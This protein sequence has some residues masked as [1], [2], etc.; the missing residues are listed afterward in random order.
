MTRHKLPS[1]GQ[2]KS[3]NIVA[4]MTKALTGRLLVA[5]AVSALAACAAPAPQTDAPA[6]SGVTAV[7]QASKSSADYRRVTRNGQEYY[8]K[9]QKVT[10]SLT[11]VVETCLTAA[12][13]EAQRNDA[14]DYVNKVQGVPGQPAGTNPMNVGGSVVQ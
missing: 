1:R 8:C 9:R 2:R 5:A 13:L 6:A 11:R 3:G 12:Q 4:A 10:A 7:G 14:Q